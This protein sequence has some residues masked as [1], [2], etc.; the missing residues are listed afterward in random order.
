MNLPHRDRS[1]ALAV[2][3]GLEILA[4]LGL[5]G[6]CGL[7]AVAVAVSPEAK[8]A[9]GGQAGSLVLS[10]AVY[11]LLGVAGIVVGAGLLSCK[12][13]A[14]ALSLIAATG[15][16]VLG[17]FVALTYALIGPTLFAGL[18]PQQSPGMP[19]PAVLTG[20]VIAISVVAFVLPGAACAWVLAGDDARLT[21]EWRDRQERWTDRCPL[22]LL[23]LSLMH[24]VSA[25]L[26]A[27]TA[28]TSPALVAGRIFTGPP[29]I[30]FYLGTSVLMAVLAVGLYRRRP[31]AW[32]TDVVLYAAGF[33]NG[34]TLLRAGTLTEFYRSMGM[35]EDQVELSSRL[36]SSGPMMALMLIALL[37]MTGWL[38][39]VKKH[40]RAQP[41]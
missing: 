5:L 9:M 1:V 21:C 26:L 22:P 23:A 41:A 37:L 33:L 14:R 39:L 3:G 35:P 25:P 30:A 38:L 2:V 18:P 4:G 8:A 12:R 27:A 10:L 11:G 28:F 34:A 17:L 15:A 29:A 7:S 13:W 16:A 19:S 36:L 6:I 31:W 40:F 32:W 24:A 20:I